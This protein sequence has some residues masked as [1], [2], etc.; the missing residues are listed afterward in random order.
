MQPTASSLKKNTMKKIV[1]TFGLIAGTV[2]A[3]MMF[4]TMPLWEKGILD[5]DNGEIVGYTSMVVA[6]SVILIAVKSYRDKYCNG[7]ITFWGGLK[8][9]LLITLV[10]G[11]MYA[12][13]WEVCYPRMSADFMPKMQEHYFEEMK[14]DGASD[15]ELEKAREE[16][17][18]FGELYQKVWVRFPMTIMEILPVGVAMSL[19]AAAIWRR[20][21]ILPHSPA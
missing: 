11:V 12:M 3:L 10:A 18:N 15:E 21:E 2:V 13:A 16:F 20:K 5:F 19:L 9:G 4:I 1:L 8:V 7:V 17:K 14:A 6:L